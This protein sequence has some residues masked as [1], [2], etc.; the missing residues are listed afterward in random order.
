[1]RSHAPAAPL[2]VRNGFFQAPA[3]AVSNASLH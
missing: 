1:M 3:N 2:G